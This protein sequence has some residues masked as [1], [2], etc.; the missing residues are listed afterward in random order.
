M[1]RQKKFCLQRAIPV[2]EADYSTLPEHFYQESVVMNLSGFLIQLIGILN[3]FKLI[4]Q[5]K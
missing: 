2:I 1:D 3:P 4:F 5:R